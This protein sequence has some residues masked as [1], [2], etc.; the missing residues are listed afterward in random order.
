MTSPDETG[1]S[2]FEPPAPAAPESDPIELCRAFARCF[3]G[4]DG[5][6]A[7]GHLERTILDRRLSPEASDQALRH[8]EG[9]RSAVAYVCALI[10][11]G[12]Q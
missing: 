10:A 7:L 8:L 11:R 6:I 4:R 12:Q 1:W 3:Q 5:E 9:Q 2:W